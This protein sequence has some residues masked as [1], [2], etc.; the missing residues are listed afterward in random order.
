VTVDRKNAQGLTQLAMTQIFKTDI[1]KL[2]AYSGLADSKQGYLLVKVLEIDTSAAN[3]ADALTNAKTEL[4]AALNA[5]YLSSYKQSLREKSK[6]KVNQKL[7]MDNNP[8][9]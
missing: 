8:D 6:I 7:L 3:D 5:E 4:S 2:P 1:S 9:Q